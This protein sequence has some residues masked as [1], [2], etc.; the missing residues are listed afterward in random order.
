MGRLGKWRENVAPDGRRRN[1]QITT[2]RARAAPA[3]GSSSRT[4]WMRIAG[5]HMHGAET[6]YMHVW[7][8]GWVGRKHVFS[9]KNS[10]LKNNPSS[11]F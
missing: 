1:D 5:F 6:L 4:I 8:V 11:I 10:I 7:S 9:L 3:A 2:S